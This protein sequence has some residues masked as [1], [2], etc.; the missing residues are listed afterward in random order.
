MMPQEAAAAGVPA[1]APVCV[2]SF[3]QR[4]LLPL[5]DALFAPGLLCPRAGA[6]LPL[7]EKGGGIYDHHSSPEA[8]RRW[9]AGKFKFR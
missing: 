3:V 7:C 8:V 1:E 6:G 4:A 9:L 2:S 5:P